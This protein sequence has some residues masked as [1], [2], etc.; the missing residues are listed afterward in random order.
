M[1][2]HFLFEQKNSKKESAAAA[3]N[4]APYELSPTFDGL[5]SANGAG[6]PVD[7]VAPGVRPPRRGKS[8]SLLLKVKPN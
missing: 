8:D 2:P 6:I 4:K 1:V 7:G 5:V 3:A